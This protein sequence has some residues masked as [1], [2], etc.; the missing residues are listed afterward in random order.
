MILR[1]SRPEMSSIWDDKFKFQ[2]MLDVE[3]AACEAMS[4][5]G[6]IPKKA[7]GNIRKKAKFNIERIKHL[8]KETNH[9][10]A[11]F[12]ST[13]QESIGP[14]GRYIHMGLTS[15][16]VTDTALALQMREAADIILKDLEAFKNVLAEKARLYK[17]T[18]MIGR[19]HGV[20][21]EPMTF[22]LKI[23][24]FYEETK[25]NIQRMLAAKDAV[26]VG[27]ISGA[28]GTF[29]NIEPV[30]EEFAC[31]KL[32][33]KEAPVS[34]QVIQRDRHAQY[35]ATIALIGATLEKLAIEIR[36]LQRTEIREVEEYFSPTQ[37]GSSAMPH[38]RN[39][40]TCERI[41]GLARILR[42]NAHAAMENVALWHERDISH[43]SVERITMP[44]ST[45]LID[46]MLNKM[47]DIVRHLIIYPHRMLENLNK[48]G[49]LIFSQKLLLEMVDKGTSR[50]KAY[51]LIQRNAMKAQG[52]KNVDFKENLLKDKD[53]TA[54]L[55]PNQ[56]TAC[57]DLR[58]YLR[59]I[60]KVFK[61]I[62]L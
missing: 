41:T 54:I 20:H 6:K 9:D 62:G 23:A 53:V 15:N 26:S 51:R 2:K 55:K 8:E 22:G 58:Y 11:A 43:S 44:D 17:H 12:V 27:K 3:I 37:K 18:P 48:T 21:A 59:N 4:K 5:E 52:E 45:I 10:V 29:S 32:G 36:G 16:D 33:L 57:F 39:P 30:V 28:V 50:D 56:I 42:A 25:R 35:M 61:R 38:K 31:K 24:I 34:S 46:Y 49:G 13:V 47:T 60:D 7:L 1:Y 19:T 40:I 14:D